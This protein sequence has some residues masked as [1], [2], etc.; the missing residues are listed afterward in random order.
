MRST[1][2]LKKAGKSIRERKMTSLA[3]KEEF[4]TYLASE[5]GDDPKTLQSYDVDLKQFLSFTKKEDVNDLTDDDLDDFLFYLE[6]KGE[7]RSTIIR[8]STCLRGFYKFLKREGYRKDIVLSSLES[9]KPEKRLPTV[10]SL[11]E[12]E[13]LFA[14]PNINEDKGLLDLTLMEVAFSCGLRVSELVGL[15]KNEV[16]LKNGYLKVYGKRKKERILPIRREALQVMEEYLKRIRNPIQKSSPLFFLHPNGNEVSRQY[17]FLELKKYAKSAQ[18]TKNISPHTLRHTYAT[19][20]L[21]NGAEL[22][23]VQELLGHADIETTQIYTH[24]SH[25][26]EEE[27]YQKGMRR[28]TT[29]KPE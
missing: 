26:K 22:R 7:K 13:R 10:L 21:E 18:I 24:L 2:I 25:K 8:K 4:L 9:P 11:E 5:K 14:Q 27:A 12:V 6:S 15:R 28:N 17:F 20:L 3:A 23:K 29:K 19:L 16:N 1:K